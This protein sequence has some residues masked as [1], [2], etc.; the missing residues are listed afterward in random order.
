M[1]NLLLCPEPLRTNH[2]ATDARREPV[3]LLKKMRGEQ[4]DFR[5]NDVINVSTQ[6]IRNNKFYSF[7]KLSIENSI[8]AGE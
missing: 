4:A 2:C 8:K 6:F 7:L 5:T 1:W 3:A